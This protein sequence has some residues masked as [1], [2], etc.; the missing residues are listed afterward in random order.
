MHSSNG[1]SNGRGSEANADQIPE[2]VHGGVDLA[3]LRS[4][5]RDPD[6]VLDFSSNILPCSPAPSV[7][8]AISQMKWDR[9]PDRNG[10]ELREALAKKWAIEAEQIVLGNGASELIHM[11]ARILA[12]VRSSTVIVGPTFSEYRRA[13]ELLNAPFHEMTL[14]TASNLE[15][16]LEKLKQHCDRWDVDTVWLCNPN[17]P[18]GKLI[19]SERLLQWIDDSPSR[20]FV[21]DESYIEF[22]DGNAS[23]LSQVRL[24]DADLRNIRL[25]DADLRNIRLGDADLRNIRLGDADLRW[26]HVRDNLIVL[27]SMTKSYAMAGLRLGYVVASELQCAQLAS[28]RVPW[29]VNA[30]ALAAGVA[31]L[32]ASD[33][34]ARAIRD[35]RVQTELVI[36]RLRQIG[37]DVT[38]SETGFFLVRVDSADAIR[39]FLLERGVL[40]RSCASFGLPEYIRI[41]VRDPDSNQ[42]LIQALLDCL[43]TKLGSDCGK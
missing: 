27:R 40:V 37:Y 23:L 21:V 29:S 3:E 32:G 14:A 4:L 42:V 13:Y 38:D 1:Q 33:H 8:E 9:Y 31:A 24:G 15:F 41:S 34:Y 36:Q 6:S 7:I 43:Q 11:I 16:D 28:I 12:P 30:M 39:R 19:C 25:G 18:T 26:K 5:G 10:I 17:N 35:L 22:V 2:A 20:L